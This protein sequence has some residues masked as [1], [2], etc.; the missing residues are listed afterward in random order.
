MVARA[1]GLIEGSAIFDHSSAFRSSSNA[2]EKSGGVTSDTNQG[3]AFGLEVTV[4]ER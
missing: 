2:I 4:G 1:S 3:M